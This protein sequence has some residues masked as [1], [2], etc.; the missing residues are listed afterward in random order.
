MEKLM[1]RHVLSKPGSLRIAFA[2]CAAAPLL[3]ACSAF[4]Q[5]P[6]PAPATPTQG[7]PTQNAVGATAPSNAEATAER[8]IVTGSNIPTAEE[9]GPNPVDTYRQEDI[10]KL[11]VR[12]STD[13]IQRLPAATGS[14][15]TENNTNGGDGRAEINLRGILAKETLVLVD[16]RR[17]APVGFAGSTVDI[18][19]I[20]FPLIDHIDILKD[21]ASAIYGADA[22]AGVFGIFLKHKFRGLEVG[23]SYGNSNLGGSNDQGEEMGY[24]LAGTGDDK[25]DIVVFAEIYNRAAIYSRDRDISSNGN[26]TRFGGSDLRSGNFAGRIDA[27]FPDVSSS[28]TLTPGLRAPLNAPGTHPY[29]INTAAGLTAAG[30]IPRVSSLDS[31]RPANGVFL[32]NFASLTP[33]IA[34]VDR[35]YFYGSV[36]RDICDKWLTFFADFKYARTFWDS[37]LA[38]TPFS[39][40]PDAF[41]SGSDFVSGDPISATGISVPTQNAFNPFS[42]ATT[43]VN[44]VGLITGVRYRSLEAGLRTDKITTNNYMFTGGL[45]GTFSDLTTNDILKTWGYE[46]GF[47]YNLDDRVEAFGGITNVNALRSALLS[48][49]PNTAF[50]MF[51]K[52]INGTGIAGRTNPSVLK[53]VFVTTNHRGNTSLTLE[54]SKLYGDIWN[55]PAGPLSFAI[56]G[57]H[58]KETANDQPDPLTASG[59]TLGATNFQPTKGN[60]DVWAMYGEVRIPVTSPS[61][62]FIGA[63]SL[64]FDIA[65]R[66]EF[67]SDFGDT[68]KPKFSVRWQPI[69]SS[70]TLRATYNEAF[71]APTLSEL[72]TSQAQSFP[73]VVDPLGLT[74]D[75]QVAETIGGN[76]GLKPENAYEWTYGGV[77]TPKFIKGL[78]LSL[79]WYH[80]DLRNI[81]ALLDPQFILNQNAKGKFPDL[82]QRDPNTGAITNIIATEMNLARIIEEGLDYEAIYQLDT[83]IFG[84]GNFGTFTFTL[85][86]TYLARYQQ[87]ASP[88]QKEIAIAGSFLGSTSGGSLPHD[89]VYTSIFYDL[90]GL[91][92]GATVHYIGQVWDTPGTTNSGVNRKIREY[93]TLDLIANYTFNFA[94]P[95]A[96]Q[97]VAGFAKDGGK[98][99]KMKDGK[100]KNVA[101]VTTASYS[102]CGWRAWLNNTTLTV[103]MNNVF[104]KSPPFVA[105]AFE[106]GYDESTASLQGRFWYVAVKKRF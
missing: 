67:F 89:R 93:T 105:G 37:G 57:E 99:V 12:S 32:Y 44:G 29:D 28:V 41:N 10:Q 35:E 84:G 102:E 20:P 98:N 97:P 47:R 59:Q 53:S 4:A 25:T 87:Q 26:F 56:G 18:N 74:P 64:E 72:F 106:N 6:S 34:A 60:R 38:P 19:T 27:Q 61:W 65:E 17:L 94:E 66:Y 83:S 31:G 50:D 23:G 40:P 9:V 55:L 71:H 42:T 46:L 45:R 75:P 80:I 62:N 8:V 85:N 95:V 88:T 81:T 7:G 39:G 5:E 30:Y 51:G 52:S 69:D 77:W 49:D 36:I 82:V 96:E 13:L 21:G 54:D 58:R 86:G 90:G 103:G 76:K 101:P 43:T 70:L 104:D 15:L 14:A 1:I 73:S 2:T 3:F 68:E 78:T 92:V 16:G 100:D 79:D 91:D 63:Y 22:V 48:T 24:L 11:G 33:A